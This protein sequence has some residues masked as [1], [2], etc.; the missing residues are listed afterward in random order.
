MDTYELEASRASA[1]GVPT[2]ELLVPDVVERS[3]DDVAFLLDAFS[4]WL[5]E[6]SRGFE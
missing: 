3:G 5:P 4:E 1:R 6:R 2:G